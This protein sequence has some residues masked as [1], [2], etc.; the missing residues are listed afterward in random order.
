MAY[1]LA[2][3]WIAKPGLEK[4]VQEILGILGEASRQE[5]G[6]ITYTTHVNPDDPREFFIY[7][8]Y[9]DISGLEAHQETVHFKEYVLEKAIPMLES[10]VRKT[11]VDF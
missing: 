5:P 3:S 10:R 4:Q 2:V 1:V 8:K 7:E 11:L 6:V 9:H